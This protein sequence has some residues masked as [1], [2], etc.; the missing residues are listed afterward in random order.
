MIS[1]GFVE[2]GDGRRAPILVG[3]NTASVFPFPSL[4]TSLISA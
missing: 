3:E 1:I 4:A 2:S